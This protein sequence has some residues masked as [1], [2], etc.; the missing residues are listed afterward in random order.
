VTYVLLRQ[1]LVDVGGTVGPADVVA[2]AA[3][4][5]AGLSTVEGLLLILGGLVVG[6]LVGL[7]L[8]VRE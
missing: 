3:T 1:A 2:R 4:V 8:S 5:G 7:T 6:G